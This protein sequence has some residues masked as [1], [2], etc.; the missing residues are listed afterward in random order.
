MSLE[1]EDGPIKHYRMKCDKCGKETKRFAYESPKVG[2]KHWPIG[3]A[4]VAEDDW[5][6]GVHHCPNCS[7]QA[8]QGAKVIVPKVGD[9]FQISDHEEVDRPLTRKAGNCLVINCQDGCKLH[10]TSETDIKVELTEQ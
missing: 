8:P 9:G 1:R 10:I 4:K 5:K 6:G 2:S 3:W 7:G